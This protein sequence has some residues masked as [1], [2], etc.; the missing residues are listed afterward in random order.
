MIAGIPIDI[1]IFRKGGVESRINTRKDSL[2]KHQREPQ[3][4][5]LAAIQIK[6]T[7]KQIK[8]FD[9]GKKIGIGAKKYTPHKITESN[10]LKN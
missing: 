1:I 10:A 6:S 7:T 3:K 5:L 8:T 9:V 2:S 4:A